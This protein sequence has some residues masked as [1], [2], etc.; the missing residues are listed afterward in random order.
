M[1]D[2]KN[3]FIAIGIGIIIVVFLAMV[4]VIGFYGG[5][6]FKNEQ[7]K[8]DHGIYKNSDTFIDGKQQAIN[9]LKSQYEMVDNEADRI[10]ILNQMKNELANCDVDKFENE[11]LKSF[12]NQVL[13]GSLDNDV[14]EESEVNNE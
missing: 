8:I 9:N 5:N 2:M 7:V 3:V 11:Q 1:D 10:T 14:I 4:V 13:N 6:F 12:A